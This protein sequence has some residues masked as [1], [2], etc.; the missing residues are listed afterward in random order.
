MSGRGI[1][2]DRVVHDVC[3][4][5]A[6]VVLRGL[7]GPSEADE[8]AGQGVRVVAGALLRSRHAEVMRRLIVSGGFMV[9]K[10]IYRS[11]LECLSVPVTSTL[12]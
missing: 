12:V 10:T 2:Q 7:E 11:R 8:P 1:G 6:E 5:D 3:E 4:A 9:V